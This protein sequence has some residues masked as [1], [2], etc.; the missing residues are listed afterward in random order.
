MTGGSRL[1]II[2]LNSSSGALRNRSLRANGG[3]TYTSHSGIIG[4][5]AAFRAH[6]I[7]VLA[8]IL[9]ITRFQWTQFC[10]LIWNFGWPCSSCTTS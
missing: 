6:P 3:H 2:R 7:D 8:R 4:T 1:P 9:D 5:A 10:A